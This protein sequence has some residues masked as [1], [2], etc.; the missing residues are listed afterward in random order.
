MDDENPRVRTR[1]AYLLTWFPE[2]AGTSLP[3]LLG[4][5]AHED[6]AVAKATSLVAVGMLGTTAHPGRFTASLDAADG[7][8]RWAAEVDFR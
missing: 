8:V 4:L 3:L 6:D 7:L 2:L 5:A 1:T